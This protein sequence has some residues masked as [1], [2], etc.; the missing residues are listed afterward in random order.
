MNTFLPAEEKYF[1]AKNMRVV[2]FKPLVLGFFRSLHQNTV[3]LKVD[4]AEN[5]PKSDLDSRIVIST[6]FIR[7]VYNRTRS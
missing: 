6:V 4:S 7:T 1:S 3:F 5:L 2:A